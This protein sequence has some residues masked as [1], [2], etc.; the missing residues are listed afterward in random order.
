MPMMAIVSAMHAAISIGV[1]SN[2][3]TSLSPISTVKRASLWRQKA[4]CMNEA[5]QRAEGSVRQIKVGST[6]GETELK[7]LKNFLGVCPQGVHS[8]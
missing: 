8:E 5:F 3:S 4:T 1:L 7:T 2:V 6:G